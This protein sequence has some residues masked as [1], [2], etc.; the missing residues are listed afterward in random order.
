MQKLK[1]ILDNSRECRGTYELVP[2]SGTDPHEVSNVLI[3][4]HNATN[5]EMHN[6][7]AHGEQ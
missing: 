4:M 1:E 6:P 2:I 7:E 5:M 3:G